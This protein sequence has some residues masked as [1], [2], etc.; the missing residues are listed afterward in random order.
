MQAVYRTSASGLLAVPWQQA[1]QL[2][3]G[4]HGDEKC[5]SVMFEGVSPFPHWLLGAT[6]AELI[7]R[8][9]TVSKTPLDN[10]QCSDW[11]VAQSR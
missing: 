2:P 7:E 6:T 10:M 11:S 8:E 3:L 9:F 1:H 4:C 5:G